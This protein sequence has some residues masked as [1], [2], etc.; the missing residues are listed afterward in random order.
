MATNLSKGANTPLISQDETE[1]TTYQ[2]ILGWRD[3][4]DAFDVDVSALLVGPDGKVRTDSDLIFYNSPS[5]ADGA[6][7]LLGK[8]SH[9]GSGEARIA[10]DLGNIPAEIDTIVI[11]AS[12]DTDEHRGFGALEDLTL[13]LVDRSDQPVIRY[14]ITD[15]STE[16]AFV[17]GEIY[18]RNDLW[19]FR[20][21]GQGWGAGLS[22]L[23]TNYGI[24]V[25]DEPEPD[26]GQAEDP[27]PEPEQPLAEV[28]PLIALSTQDSQLE[29]EKD[30]AK[31]PR[32]VRTRKPRTTSSV[33]PQLTLAGDES[34]QAA[35]LFSVS[36]I[37]G[38]DEQ[39]KRATSAL[40]ATMMA[41]RDFGRSLA[42]RF[43]APSGTVE[44]Y[45]EV[46]FPHGETNVFPDGVIRVARAGRIWTAL[47][48][49]K[50]GTGQLRREQVERYLDVAKREG[51]DAVIT[52]SN[53]LMVPGGEHPAGV[54]RRKLRKVALH[55]ISWSEVLHEAQMQL[56]HRGVGDR[57]Q[58]WI[59]AELIRYLEHPRSGA[60][61]FDDM[62][63]AWVPVRESVAAGTLRPTDKKVP[64]VAAAWE[65]LTRQLCLR[66]TSQLGVPVTAAVPRKVAGDADARL[67]A[68]MANLAANGTLQT[69]LRIP[70]A[71]GPMTITADLR[72]GQ[73]QVSVLVDA[74]TDMTNVR[75]INWMLRQLKDAPDLLLVEVRFHRQALT[76]CEQLKDVRTNNSPLLPDPS[77]EV[78]EFKLTLVSPMGTK[79]N[80]VRG[81]FIV[82]INSTVDA[83]YRT[84][85][86]SLKPWAT[87]APK[88][89]AVSVDEP[90]ESTED[91]TP[92]ADAG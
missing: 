44:T 74:P 9:D 68:T 26:D 25:D 40:L 31:A 76:S 2:V 1:D 46:Q 77:A 22:G 89:P 71:V 27:G 6:V 59:L 50:T 38:A 56:A 45:L 41:V 43:G 47:L 4:T 28:V 20:A 88:M 80:G 81:G 8:N 58:A 72:V 62:G 18:R 29:A 75:R 21:V 78:R 63:S 57:L 42:L 83:F 12:S 90:A 35:R 34:W 7:R 79:R 87:P 30:K 91:S 64:A 54:D 14:D 85:V 61:E 67:Q 65:K 60:A 16:T 39:E 33:L 49:T 37:G 82:S 17:F 70:N 92:E 53:E 5:G 11:A 32:G 51:F 19:K 84:V 66:M 13:L 24:Q 3:P 36:G 86:E 48:E 10:I 52:L 23:V 15:A 55:H 73:I 69:T